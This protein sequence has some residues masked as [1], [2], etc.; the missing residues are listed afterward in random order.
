MQRFF[1]NP[2]RLAL[3]GAV[4]VLTSALLG[5]RVEKAFS[6]DNVV[7]QIEKYS[8]VMNMVQKFYVDKVSVNDLNEAAIVGLLNKL[9]PHSVYMPPRNV[10]ESDEQFSGRFEGIGVT[11][12]IIKDTI[13]V[14]A[15]IPGGPSDLLGIRAGDKIVKIDGNPAIKISEDSVRKQLRGTKGTKVNVSIARYGEHQPLEF[16]ITRDVIPIVS[17]MA[18]FMV[19]PSTGYVDVGRFASNTYDELMDALNDLKGKGMQRLIL[20]LRGNPGGYL[21]QA[22]RIADEFIGGSK[23]IV[24]T[25]GR[26]SQFDDVL[27]SRPG[28]TYEKTPLVVLVDNGSASASEIVSGALQ[29]LDRAIV[30]GQ[31]TFGKGLVQRQFPLQD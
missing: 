2:R 8:E 19:D 24:Y 12:T 30:V 29:D 23:T 9:D 26:V 28:D 25:K 15:P 3:T 21:E 6:D 4:L 14:D 17:V 16:T 22:V 31:T 11:F 13:T 10:K 7:G 1:Y 27:T 20:D 18:H 5:A